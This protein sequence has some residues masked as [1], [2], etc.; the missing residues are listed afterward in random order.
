MRSALLSLY[1]EGVRDS[2]L[3]RGSS[4]AVLQSQLSMIPEL[5]ELGWFYRVVVNWG[6][7]PWPFYPCID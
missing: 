7:G 6:D 2:G 4:W 3:D 5:L 1:S